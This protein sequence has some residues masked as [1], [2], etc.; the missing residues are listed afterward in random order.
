MRSWLLTANVSLG[1]VV[2]GCAPGGRPAAHWNSDK[3]T[4]TDL[5]ADR[6]HSPENS[7]DLGA[8]Y[9]RHGKEEQATRAYRDTASKATRM[10]TRKEALLALARLGEEVATPSLG[11]CA[12]LRSAL[13]CDQTYYACAVEWEDHFSCGGDEGV[14]LQVFAYERPPSPEAYETWEI[15]PDGADNDSTELA[16]KVESEPPF[17][18][19]VPD[20]RTLLLSS[21]GYVS[22]KEVCDEIDRVSVACE[23]VMA[24]ACRGRVG[25]VCTTK[26]DEGKSHQ[27]VGEFWLEHR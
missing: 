16:T 18:F 7:M 27:V 24:D 20:R 26:A 25:L 4:A 12:P 23:V 9:E 10:A 11:K 21:D 6:A 15:E 5:C 2:V 19:S 22:G 13:A 17:F 14:A 3:A 8:C 1:L